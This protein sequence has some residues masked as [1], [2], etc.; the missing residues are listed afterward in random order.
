MPLLLLAILTCGVSAYAQ[1]AGIE[2]HWQG[3][4]DAGAARL[5]LALH[6]E[7]EASGSLSG[8]MDSIDQGANGIPLSAVA[9][10]EDRAVSFTIPA[11]GGSYKGKLNAAGDAID[12]TWTQGPASL[13]LGFRRGNTPAD[14]SKPQDPKKPYPYEEREVVFEN[15][16]QGNKLA[17]T[18]T[19]PKNAKSVPAVV[20]LTG[21]GPQ[22]RDEALFGHRPFLVLADH[23]TRKGIAVLRFDDRGVGGSTAVPR[24]TTLDFAKDAIAAVEFLKKDPAINAARIGLI[25]H[26]EGGLMAP[27][28]ASQ[29]KDVAFIVL[30]AGTGVP[31]EEVMYEQAAAIIRAN[32][33]NAEQ[34]A[35]N[36]QVQEKIFALVKSDL[37]D[38][39]VRE[40]VREAAGANQA[41]MAGSPW[42]RTFVKLDPRTYLRKLTCP[43]LAL[44]GELDLQVLPKQNL[45][46]IE[47][48]LKEGG[49]KDFKTAALPKLNHLFQTAEK[50]TPDEYARLDETIA[51]AALHAISDW[52]LEKTTPKGK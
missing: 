37:D 15:S 7:K 43:V 35:A 49:N 39:A 6:I 18:L 25:G 52:I 33:G 26:S 13:P 9:L 46:E 45:P 5:R 19:V 24:S 27:I 4:L 14:I 42:F 40:K 44:N 31:G 20:L 2:G 36:R 17:G 1:S 48:A 34:V 10:T 21:S 30:L 22:N 38:D 8:K 23:L 50:G 47:K 12:G 3:T 41:A 32:G 11:I 16:A 29:S 51:P 28:A